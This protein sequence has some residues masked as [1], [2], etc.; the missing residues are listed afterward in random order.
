MASVSSRRG[1]RVKK[2][3]S[4]IVRYS[5]DNLPIDTKTDWAR[6]DAMRDEDIDCSD[7]P[8]LSEEFWKNARLMPPLIPK[9]PVSLRID[10]DI[11]A[12]FRGRGKRYQSRINAVLRAYVEA[13]R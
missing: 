4:R 1:R 3:K 13:H 12:W 11:L 8:E 9:T 10:P 6:L 7:I 5:L 2:K